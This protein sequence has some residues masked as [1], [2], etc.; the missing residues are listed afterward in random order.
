VIA[1]L[2]RRYRHDACASVWRS[3]ASRSLLET[4][5]QN[6]NQMVGAVCRKDGEALSDGQIEVAL[7]WQP[8]SVVL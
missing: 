6:K 3:V 2:Q 1:S 7:M 4:L 5:P 8:V